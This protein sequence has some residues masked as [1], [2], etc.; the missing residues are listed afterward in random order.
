M[1]RLKDS[2]FEIFQKFEKKY[3]LLDPVKAFKDSEFKYKPKIEK[4]S[5]KISG[6]I[7]QQVLNK[8]LNWINWKTH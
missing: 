5:P 8:G 4:L 1:E 2:Y 6:Y 7:H 3:I